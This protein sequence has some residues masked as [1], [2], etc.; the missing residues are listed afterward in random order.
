MMAA[1][2]MLAMPAAAVTNNLTSTVNSPRATLPERSKPR[3]KANY[4]KRRSGWLYG[5]GRHSGERERLR[6]FNQ[7]INGQ[8]RAENGLVVS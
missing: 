7:I 1:A 8:L 2:A 5:G 3:K 6:R 4:H